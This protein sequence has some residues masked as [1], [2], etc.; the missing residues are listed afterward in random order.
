MTNIKEQR[1]YVFH[2]S[3]GI[4]KNIRYEK[5]EYELTKQEKDLL[6]GELIKCFENNTKENQIRFIEEIKTELNEKIK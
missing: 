2:K 3:T 5:T 6:H 4:N 1:M